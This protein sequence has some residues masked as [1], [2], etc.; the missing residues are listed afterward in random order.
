MRNAI[1]KCF[2]GISMVLQVFSLK[3]QESEK[4]TLLF[5]FDKYNISR[6]GR[7]TL[8]SILTINAKTPRQIKLF[9]HTDAIGGDTYNDHLSIRRVSMA[10]KYL[11]ERGIAPGRIITDSGLGKR[12]P[13]NNNADKLERKVNRRVEI[14]LM[15][16]PKTLIERIRDTSTKAGSRI[17]LQNLHFI[18]NRHKLMPES[19]PVMLELLQVLRK[20]PTLE[21]EIEGHVCCTGGK[22]GYDEDAKALMLS[23]NRAVYVYN[24]LIANGIAKTRLS[25][26]AYGNSKPLYPFEDT[27]EKRMMNRR[28]E[29]KIVRK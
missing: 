22:E 24:Y 4:F 17:L 2:L 27:Q 11:L 3:G 6:E 26:K 25:W 19:W 16:L 9:G 21:I 7:I 18:G 14:V 10:K 8:D 13:L 5:E 29:I 23:T 1:V 12:K 15:L 20:N 28:V